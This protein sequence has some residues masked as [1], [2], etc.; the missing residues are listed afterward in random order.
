M[1]LRFPTFR[2]PVS[3][4]FLLLMLPVLP[5]A[6]AQTRVDTTLV[7]N[8]GIRLEAFYILP[9]TAPPTAGWPAILFVHGF[10]GSMN[11]NQALAQSAAFGGYAA[12]SFSVRGQA[13]SEGVFDFFTSP[14]VLADLSALIAATKS[15]PGVNPDRVA[16]EGGSQGG[17][18][19]WAAAA[20]NL[21]V[22]SVTSVIANGRFDENWTE[23]NALNWTFARAIGVATARLDASLKDVVNNAVNSGNI[24]P[25]ESF[26]RS[27]STAPL[28][29]ATTTPV[30]M[31]V[32]NHDGFFNQSAALRQFAA[33]GAPKR[34]MTYPAGH[35]VPPAGSM[36]NLYQQQVD[37]WR[38]YW[39]KDDVSAAHIIDPA[40]AVV[41][42]DGATA[43]PHVFAI[44]DSAC[45]L[46]APATLPQGLS[47]HTWYFGPAGLGSTPPSS[48]SQQTMTY[49]NFLGSNVLTFRSEPF[50]APMTIAGAQGG[51]VLR[52]DGTGSQYQVSLYL[53]D[54][55]PATGQS[56]PIVRGHA[57]VRD[58]APGAETISFDLTSAMHT[59]AAGH[60]IEARM[61][62]G[63]AL[64]PNTSVD[65]GNYVL[66]PVQ[67]SVNTMFLGGNEPS[68]LTLLSYDSAAV[69]A[70]ARAEAPTTLHVGQNYPNP[71]NPSTT[72]S[73]ASA[74]GHVRVS[75][76]TLAGAEV[77]V[78][79]DGMHAA[80]THH[81]V[82]HADR[83]ASGIY[84]CR[85]QQ[86]TQTRV[87]P[88]TLLR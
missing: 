60:V 51:V 16:V 83:A 47:R 3:C 54:V 12:M 46:H 56:K 7:M 55:D 88:M 50:A 19:A 35:T 41:M 8:D 17:L 61:H 62:G 1:R 21:G 84:V 11:D 43:A 27:F 4:V 29:A 14:R 71:F 38:A 75:V 37:D 22:R 18:L 34:I 44:A 28:E 53:Y 87:R 72:I 77:A 6:D 52:T 33:I 39:L 68:R 63:M 25:V 49:A 81:V 58:N 15:L 42:M 67:G 45:W 80:G 30:A 73:Y 48:P 5:R 13:A 40:T 32:S 36:R 85:V 20:H 82:W 66:G 70:I 59:V 65:F 78:L 64:L 69:T 74:A 31:F 26:L 86:G 10:N 76:H 23:N 57:Q 2:I 79:A 9:T 24:A